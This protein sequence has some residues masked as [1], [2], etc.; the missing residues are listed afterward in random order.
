M[1]RPALSLRLPVYKCNCD[2]C[3]PG[4]TGSRC[5]T[6]IDECAD[7]PCLHGGQCINGT[8]FYTC[9]CNQTLRNLT[10]FSDGREVTFY[11]GWTGHNCELDIN[12]CLEPM[13]C[14]GHGNCENRNGTYQCLCGRLPN[15]VLTTGKCS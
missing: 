6:D 13:V 9:N 10:R 15:G 12:E 3:S 4:W 8:G 7:Q 11:T 5:E 14:L 2:V 1:C